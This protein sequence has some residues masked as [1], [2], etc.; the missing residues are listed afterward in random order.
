M[1]LFSKSLAPRHAADMPLKTLDGN[2]LPFISV[3]DT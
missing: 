3:K 2:M 1:R